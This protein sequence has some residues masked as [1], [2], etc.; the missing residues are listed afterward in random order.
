MAMTRHDGGTAD[1]TGDRTDRRISLAAGKLPAQPAAAAN[2]N[3]HYNPPATANNNKHYNPAAAANNNK[4]YNPPTA[5]NINDNKFYN[6][7]A[8]ES[9]KSRHGGDGGAVTF[10]N[11]QRQTAGGSNVM[12]VPLLSVNKHRGQY[13]IKMN[14]MPCRNQGG[15][16]VRPN[17]V[18]PV[19]VKLARRDAAALSSS[20][21]SLEF[22]LMPQYEKSA[23]QRV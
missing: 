14:P 9:S 21:S 13:D 22:E 5:A 6:P 18:D 16:W 7:A 11:V 23:K 2:N 17:N 20:Q 1:Q 3:K 10:T 15:E 4:H 8:A 12:D 19:T